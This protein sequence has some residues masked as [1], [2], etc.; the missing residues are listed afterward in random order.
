MKRPR[1][2]RPALGGPSPSDRWSRRDAATQLVERALARVAPADEH[3]QQHER[4]R[5]LQQD[6]GHR[7]GTAIAAS[8]WSNSETRLVTAR[9]HSPAGASATVSIT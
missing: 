4:R 3:E 9:R 7:T 5:E 6:R 2:P 1:A 8:Y